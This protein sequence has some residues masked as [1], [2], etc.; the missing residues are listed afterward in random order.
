LV[1]GK[2]DEAIVREVILRRIEGYLALS[3][4]DQDYFITVK[5][6]QA[7]KIV[8][9]AKLYELKRQH[10]GLRVYQFYF[11]LFI[12]HPMILWQWHLFENDITNTKK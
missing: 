11:Q 5:A 12:H 6:F 2:P 4:P 9:I 8:I 1:N 3:F 10:P 7:F